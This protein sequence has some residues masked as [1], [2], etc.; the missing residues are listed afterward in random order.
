MYDDRLK[1][2]K[3]AAVIAL[4]IGI[5]A[6]LFYVVYS[7]SLFWQAFAA[8]VT[9]SILLIIILVLLVL[10][11]YLWLKNFLLKR[12]FNKQETKLEQ[13]KIELSRCKTR[14]KQK[15]VEDSEKL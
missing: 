12:E 13:I 7:F 14:L 1:T 5:L 8:G 2:L 15:S 6:V 9:I 10:I 4:V 3:I 11:V